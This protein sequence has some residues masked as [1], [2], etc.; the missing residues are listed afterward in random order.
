[1]S[2]QHDTEQAALYDF[3]MKEIGEHIC[4]TVEEELTSPHLNWWPS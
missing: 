4:N 1:M 3:F 2:S